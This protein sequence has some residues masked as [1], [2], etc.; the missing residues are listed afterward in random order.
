[1]LHT[2]QGTAF[3]ILCVDEMVLFASSMN[4]LPHIV[5][6]LR[7]QFSVKDM[8][9]LQYFL[10]INVRRSDNY[11]EDLLERAGM[12]N[13][14]PLPTP[15][16]TKPKP[17]SADGKPITEASFYRSMAGA[18][19]YLTVTCPDIA[20]AIQ[21]AC[22]HMH[23]PRDVHFTMLKRILRYI[24]E[25]PNIGIHLRA[26]TSPTLTVYFDADWAGC[27]DTR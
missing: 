16:D 3:L 10:G 18:L 2:S 14:K 8:G 1:V 26:T 5:T 4:L 20:F 12:S 7:S 11:I 24:K 23:S 22:L 17:S 13:C 25:T 21:Q 6:Q 15:V 19:Q 9:P 27:P